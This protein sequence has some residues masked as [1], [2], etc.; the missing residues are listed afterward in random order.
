MPLSA[1]PDLA[2]AVDAAEVPAVLVA[3]GQADDPLDR[4][5]AGIVAPAQ[6]PSGLPRRRDPA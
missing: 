1:S 2:A 3:D 4:A 5:F 6:E